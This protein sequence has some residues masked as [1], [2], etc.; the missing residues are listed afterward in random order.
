MRTLRRCILMTTIL[1]TAAW[2]VPAIGAP[3]RVYEITWAYKLDWVP[4]YPITRFLNDMG[5]DYSY[6]RPMS[7]LTANLN[8][9]RLIVSEFTDLLTVGE[10]V[11]RM[12]AP[13]RQVKG[14]LCLPLSVYEE[15]LSAEIPGLSVKT[16]KVRMVPYDQDAT[17]RTVLSL[18]TVVIDPGHG[19]ADTGAVSPSGIQEK[20]LVLSIAKRLR[21]LMARETSIKTVLTREDDRFVSL[22]DRAALANSLNADL[23]ISI[24]ANATR[25]RDAFGAEIYFLNLKASDEEAKRSAARENMSLE[26]EGGAGSGA[27]IEDLKAIMWDLVQTEIMVESSRFAEILYNRFHAVLPTHG[28]GVRQA[29]FYVLM[30]TQMPSILVEV[31]FLSNRAEAVQLCDAAYQERIAGAIF[32]AILYYDTARSFAVEEQ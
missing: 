31:G 15:I 28:K 12:E 26:I 29:P 16:D 13:P 10:K 1:L 18:H 6:S 17:K 8:D 14:A 25:Q 32:E 7:K 30:G 22:S 24:H 3:E 23:F 4:Y 21:N 19:G 5:V 2:I 20:K 27:G 11:F 9:V